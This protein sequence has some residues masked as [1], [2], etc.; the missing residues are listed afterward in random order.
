[1]FGRTHRLQT[2]DMNSCLPTRLTRFRHNRIGNGSTLARYKSHC[3]LRNCPFKESTVRSKSMSRSVLKDLPAVSII[4]SLL[5][6]HRTM[7]NHA[8][9][10]AFDMKRV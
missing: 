9:E 6:L 4:S 5:S 7:P 8:Y 1:V 3:I 2:V 10:N